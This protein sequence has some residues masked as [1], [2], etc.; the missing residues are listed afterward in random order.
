MVNILGIAQITDVHIHSKK[1][2]M[3]EQKHFSSYWHKC[4]HNRTNTATKL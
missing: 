4:D 3:F 1:I 2:H